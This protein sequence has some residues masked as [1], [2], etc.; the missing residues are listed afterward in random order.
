MRTAKLKSIEDSEQVGLYSICFDEDSVSE[1]EKFMQ[2]F[3]NDTSVNLEYQRI[4]FA[5]KKI[6]AVGVL[7]RFF[8]PEGKM[9]DRTCALSI[10]TR[11]LRLYCLRLSDQIL[12]LGNGGVKSTATYQEDDKLCGYVCDLQE[13][14]MLLKKA[15]EKGSISIEQTVITNIDTATFN[16]Q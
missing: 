14:D 15:Q 10:D 6:L 12:I 8:R 1:F 11:R 5:L 2:K 4:I 7:E 13:F 3:M 16:L 9:A